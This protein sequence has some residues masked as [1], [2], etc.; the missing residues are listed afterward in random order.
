MHPMHGDDAVQD[1]GKLGRSLR[2][3]LLGTAAILMVPLVA[4]RFT[5]EVNWGPLDFVAAA[6][7]LAGT[8]SAYVLL[9]RKLRMVSQ[10][11]AI[12]GGLLLTLLLVWAELAV[13]VFG[14]PLAGS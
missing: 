8:G 13:G 10:R 3:I 6:I 9:T 11:R 2:R 7:L 5:K 1:D 12:G 4:M 14:S